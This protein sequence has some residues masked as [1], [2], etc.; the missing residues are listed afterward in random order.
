[1]P[2]SLTSVSTSHPWKKR[3]YASVTTQRQAHRS[4]FGCLSTDGR[5]GMLNLVAWKLN[6]PRGRELRK[7]GA[8]CKELESGLLDP[9]G[10]IPYGLRRV[11]L[12]EGRM[13]IHHYETRSLHWWY[14]QAPFTLTRT[15]IQAVS[16]LLKTPEFIQRSCKGI[17]T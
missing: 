16:C 9:Y 5:T 13:S 4:S 8:G 15:C 12:A 3:V 10:T 14:N 6:G 11:L 7:A 17:R 2:R 1:M